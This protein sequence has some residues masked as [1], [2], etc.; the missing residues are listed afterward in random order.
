MSTPLEDRPPP[1]VPP[2]VTWVVL[3]ALVLLVGYVAG[4]VV[5]AWR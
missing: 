2:W 4:V 5:G 3:A 1:D